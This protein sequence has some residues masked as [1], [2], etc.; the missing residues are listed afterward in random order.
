LSVTALLALRGRSEHATSARTAL[1]AVGTPGAFA[2]EASGEAALEAVA[3]D[4]SSS[5]NCCATV[6]DNFVDLRYQHRRST[7]RMKGNRIS[8]GFYLLV[9]EFYMLTQIPVTAIWRLLEFSAL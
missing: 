2:A 8:G 3:A 9:F 1:T 6:G 7:A 5:A 4:V